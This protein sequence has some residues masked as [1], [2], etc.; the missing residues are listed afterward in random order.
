MA[1]Q[2][3]THQSLGRLSPFEVFYGREPGGDIATFELLPA[4]HN[5]KD[6]PKYLKD[7]R[8]NMENL[9]KR[10]QENQY[11]SSE[12]M[13]LRHKNKHP[14]SEYKKDDTVIVKIT[15]SDEGISKANKKH[16]LRA[17][18]SCSAIRE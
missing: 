17:R 12:K 16:L 4:C 9:L 8:K 18:R 11:R 7:W 3:R 14:P 13:V 6:D 5:I 2:H 1:I 10:V 15:K